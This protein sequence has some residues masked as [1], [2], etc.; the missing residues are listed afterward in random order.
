MGWASCREEALTSYSLSKWRS[1]GT[2]FSPFSF[3]LGD[4][5]K[6]CNDAQGG[7]DCS[8]FPRFCGA[9][10]GCRCP[11]LSVEG[12]ISRK[13]CICP[14]EP[15]RIHD[16]HAVRRRQLQME[17][18]EWQRFLG[19]MRWNRTNVRLG[20]ERL[21]NTRWNGKPCVQWF[22]VHRDWCRLAAVSACKLREMRQ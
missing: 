11:D 18:N 2:V 1:S 15:R 4:S 9:H 17:A 3:Q 14:L 7:M 6:E 20:S 5:L 16:W 10:V 19:S 13:R 21:F 8:W 22:W 12:E